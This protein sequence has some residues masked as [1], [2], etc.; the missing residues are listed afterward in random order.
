MICDCLS[1]DGT[2]IGHVLSELDVGV[3]VRHKVPVGVNGVAEGSQFMRIVV[4]VGFI[5]TKIFF[6]F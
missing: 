3:G 6:I 5:S 1:L 4:G 2:G